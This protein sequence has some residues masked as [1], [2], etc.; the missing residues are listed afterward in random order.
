MAVA[1]LKPATTRD[2]NKSTRQAQCETLRPPSSA[3]PYHF[4]AYRVCVGGGIRG[5]QRT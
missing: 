2:T 3:P 1:A 4:T 5:E